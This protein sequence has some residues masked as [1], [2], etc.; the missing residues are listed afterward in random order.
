MVIRY[1]T[2][3]SCLIHFRPFGDAEGCLPYSGGTVF[4]YWPINLDRASCV[5]LFCETKSTLSGPNLHFRMIAIDFIFD[6]YV[7]L[8]RLLQVGSYPIFVYPPHL[9]ALPNRR[10]P[11][12]RAT[13]LRRNSK[14]L[15]PAA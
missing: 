11:Q 1:G 4:I 3:V 9:A 10:L 14:T 2:V 8:I 15:G 6:G 5:A 7:L 12:L 13:L